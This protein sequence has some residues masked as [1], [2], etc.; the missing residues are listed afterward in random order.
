MDKKWTSFHL[1][2]HSFDQLDILLLE[3][4]EPVMEQLNIDWFF[5]RYWYGGPHI[6]VRMLHVNEE[7]KRYISEKFRSY[8]DTHPS[9][10]KLDVAQFYKQYSKYFSLE[11][12]NSRNV[13]WYENNSVVESEYVPEINRY[14]GLKGIEIN[15]D[16][17]ISNTKLT[18]KVLQS[19]NNHR[20]FLAL[21]SFFIS[22]M[23]MEKEGVMSTDSFI[24]YTKK[25]VT[26]KEA[27]NQATFLFDRHKEHL[28]KRYKRINH[29]LGREANSHV[30]LY[31]TNYY[32]LFH[33]LVKMMKLHKLPKDQLITVLTSQMHMYCNRLGL[34]PYKEMLLYKLCEKVFSLN[35][36][37]VL[38]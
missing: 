9:N 21:D 24:Q 13:E 31:V 34:S 35:K 3:L 38:E 17:F 12:I 23:I 16:Y 30:Q 28:I 18:V 7:E 8:L 4:I 1:Y 14:G 15:E 32:H 27:V 11:N 6:R 10:E 26:Q 25:S 2:Y 20:F 36:R 37:E 19:S 5:I 29:I 33:N 22:L